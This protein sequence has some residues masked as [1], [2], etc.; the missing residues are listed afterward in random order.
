M[1]VEIEGGAWLR[2][3]PAGPG[4]VSGFFECGAEAV[5]VACRDPVLQPVLKTPATSPNIAGANPVTTA[6]NKRDSGTRMRPCGP[7]N[8]GVVARLSVLD[9]FRPAGTPG[10]AGPVGV[11]ATDV[12]GPA[13]ELVPV[14]AA[15]A[16]D[17]EACAVLVEEA[18]IQAAHD[19]AAARTQAAA[20]LSRARLEAGAARAEAAARVG[21][22][23][24]ERD[25]RAVDQARRDAAALEE[26]GLARIPAVVG[27]IIDTML[28]SRITGQK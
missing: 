13:A 1:L 20:V 18:R 19:V 5:L 25:T 24:A 7:F 26:S 12:Q 28:S 21:R 27:K 4:L 10:P 17:V 15:L 8:G 14:F 11:P 2:S 9:R 22:D 16:A 23:A 3:G 6:A